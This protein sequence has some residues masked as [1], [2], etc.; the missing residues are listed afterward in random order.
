LIVKREDE[1]FDTGKR[2]KY[3]NMVNGGKY[4][5]YCDAEKKE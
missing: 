2:G 1:Y 5:I 4:K 3:L